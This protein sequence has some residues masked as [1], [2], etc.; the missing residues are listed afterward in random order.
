MNLNLNNFDIAEFIVVALALIYS[1]VS[2]ELGHGIVAYWVGDDTAK[3]QGRLSLNPLK[4]IDI[5]GLISM[6]LFKFGWAKP[7]PINPNKFRH[8][9]VGLFLVSIAGI[10][11]NILSAFIAMVVWI[12]LINRGFDNKYIIK[13][14]NLIIIY[15]ISLASFNL[16]PIPPLDGSK[17][18]LSF[19]PKKFSDWMLKVE[20]FGFVIIIAVIMLDLLDGPFNLVFNFI[21]ETMFSFAYSLVLFFVR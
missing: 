18:V 6:F 5:L 10:V 7:V 17:I 15:G 1:I 14:L 11:V 8:K 4:H 16:M 21:I 9:R 3:R 20:R 12:I 2:H 19:L 13:F